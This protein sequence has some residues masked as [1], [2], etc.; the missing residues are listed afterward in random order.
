MN[1]PDLK[2]PDHL[3]FAIPNSAFYFGL[4]FTITTLAV[5]SVAKI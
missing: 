3:N 5:A 2:K 4:L 1:N